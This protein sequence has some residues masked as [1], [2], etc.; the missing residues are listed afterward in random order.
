MPETMSAERQPKASAIKGTASAATV[1][2]VPM[3]LIEEATGWKLRSRW[4]SEPRL[5]EGVHSAQAPSSAPIAT[6][7]LTSNDWRTALTL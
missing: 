6:F 4:L 5:I 1:R 3:A 2:P 7:S